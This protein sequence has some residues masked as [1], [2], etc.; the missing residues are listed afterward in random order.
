[1]LDV[2][3]VEITRPDGRPLTLLASITYVP[4]INGVEMRGMVADDPEV[5]LRS[6]I[7]PASPLLVR[8]RGKHARVYA[9]HFETV[10]TFPL[11]FDVRA[12]LGR[13][14]PFVYELVVLRGV[15][16]EPQSAP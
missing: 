2:G 12:R 15:R 16:I 7:G 8:L 6:E 5:S 3:S 1:M 9:L 13:S 10:Q 11:D 14:D 4:A